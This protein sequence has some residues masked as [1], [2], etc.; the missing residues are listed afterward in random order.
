MSWSG[1]DDLGACAFVLVSHAGQAKLLEAPCK[2]GWC[3][4]SKDD[5]LENEVAISLMPRASAELA[6]C[7][8]MILLTGQIMKTTCHCVCFQV[9]S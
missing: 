5:L 4:A 6:F 7:F 9:T 8:M 3:V 1:T 2:E